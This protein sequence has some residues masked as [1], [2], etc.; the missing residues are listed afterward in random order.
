MQRK[1]SWGGQSWWKILCPLEW[2]ARKVTLSHFP[3]QLQVD[4]YSAWPLWSCTRFCWPRFGMFHHPDWAIGSYRSG[5]LSGGT[6]STKPCAWPPGSRNTNLCYPF[7]ELKV[8]I[9]DVLCLGRDWCVLSDKGLSHLWSFMGKLSPVMQNKTFCGVVASECL[10]GRWQP[11]L[12]HTID[13][14]ALHGLIIE[15]FSIPSFVR[16]CHALFW[17]FPCPAWTVDS[18]SS[19]PQSGELPKT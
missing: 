16:F 15:E 17:E 8:V 12:F 10:K 19:G 18:C 11:S 9:K 13:K 7:W 6:K 1:C 4:S 3:Q 14:T 5:L 2:P